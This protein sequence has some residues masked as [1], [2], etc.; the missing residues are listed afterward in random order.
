MGVTPGDT[1]SLIGS[2]DGSTFYT[3]LGEY[4]N[5]AQGELAID[6]MPKLPARFPHQ[7]PFK[8]SWS[9]ATG[10]LTFAID[11]NVYQHVAQKGWREA[12]GH[13]R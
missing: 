4:T 1:I 5:Q 6:F 13:M 8:A 3:L 9:S 10:E 12:S 7:P 11:G 2:D